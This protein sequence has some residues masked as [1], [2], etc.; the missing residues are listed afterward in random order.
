MRTMICLIIAA[1]LSGCLPIGI[2]GSSAPLRAAGV[3]ESPIV[4]G[5]DGRVAGRLN[6]PFTETQPRNR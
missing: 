4:A 6:G 3:G 2:K 5:M 1:L